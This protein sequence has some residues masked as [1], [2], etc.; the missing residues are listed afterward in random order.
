MIDGSL[1]IRGVAKVVPLRFTFNGTAPPQ[2]GES[3]RVA[4]HGSAATK[5]AEFG[6]T[7]DLLQELGASPSPGQDVQ[8]EIDSEAL[9][10]ISTQPTEEKP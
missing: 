6:M 4:F 5:R 3:A 8:I 9:S 2:P 10:K 1:T 7:R